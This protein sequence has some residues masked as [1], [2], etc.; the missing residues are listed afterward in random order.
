MDLWGWMGEMVANYGYF[1]AFFI[2]L[3]GNFTIFFPVP[4]VVTIYAFGAVLN[5]FLLG[6]TCGLGSTVGEFSAYMIGRGGRR[7]LEDRYGERL[8]G[9]KLLVQR[10]GALA[11]F[12]FALL[13]L[14]DDLILIPLGILRYD[15]RKAIF[16]MVIGKMIMCLSVAY[17]GKYSYEI[18]REVFKSS[19]YLG[20]IASVILLVVIMIALV[21]IDWTRFVDIPEENFK[22]GDI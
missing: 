19:G 22:A 8:R 21:K 10:Y 11:I 7:V 16:S 20:G 5:P 9:A 4:F 2:S 17:A 18:V 14:P 1:G 12:L 6:V 3:F 13:P 15:L